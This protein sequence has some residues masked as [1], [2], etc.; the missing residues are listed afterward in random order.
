M[1]RV[2]AGL[3]GF[4]LCDEGSGTVLNDTSGYVSGPT[5]LTFSPGEDYSWNGTHGVDF[6][7]A[8]AISTDVPDA[9]VAAVI[10][11]NEFTVEVWQNVADDAQTSRR[12][13]SFYDDDTDSTY[14]VYLGA[15]GPDFKA[16]YKYDNGDSLLSVS[17]P[18]TDTAGLLAGVTQSTIFRCSLDTGTQDGELFIDGQFTV[19]SDRTPSVGLSS[20]EGTTRVH[21]GGQ[22]ETSELTF[23]GLMLAIYDRALSDAEIL[24]NFNEGPPPFGPTPPPDPDVGVYALTVKVDNDEGTSPQTFTWT[25]QETLLAPVWSTIPDQ[26]D[27][28]NTLPQTLEASLYVTSNDGQGLF[29]WTLIAAPAGF[30]IDTNGR[31][32]CAAGTAVAAHTMSVRV[33][34]VTGTST[35]ATFTWNVLEELLGPQWGTI[36]NQSDDED[37][38]PQVLDTSVYVT[39]N[40]GPLVSW[41]LFSSPIGFSVDQSGVVTCAAGTTPGDHTVTVRVSNDTGTADSIFTW[42]VVAVGPVEYFHEYN[43][44]LGAIAFQRLSEATGY[45]DQ[46]FRVFV[47]VNEPVY[48][49][50]PFSGAVFLPAVDDSWRGLLIERAA[51]NLL[52]DSTDHFSDPPWTHFETTVVDSG[53]PNTLRRVGAG[54]ALV[55]QATVLGSEEYTYSIDVNEH[56]SYPG[57]LYV[58]S[59]DATITQLVP[60]NAEPQVHRNKATLTLANPLPGISIND[61]GAGERLEINNSQLE[62]GDSW[63]SYIKTLSSTASRAFVSHQAPFVDLGLD[64]AAMQNT[65]CGQLK[66]FPTM[67]APFTNA[68]VVFQM[69]DFN[70]SH[71]MWLAWLA[72]GQLYVEFMFS[73]V[74]TAFQSATL[75]TPVREDL[76]DFRWKIG[77]SE[78]KVW[79]NAEVQSAAVV[80]DWLGNVTTLFCGGGGD[81]ANYILRTIRINSTDPGD[82][83]IEG[84]D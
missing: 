2:T 75:T 1:A 39:S 28:E 10:A 17:N 53:D 50:N 76:V 82:A 9:V 52:E 6:V 45:D 35:S 19:N 40:S 67:D 21:F 59:C 60:Y 73:G 80:G 70:P 14:L 84:W 13:F 33:S 81:S 11:S 18:L 23:T 79:F 54:T 64:P 71:Y 4:Y 56:P 74:S 25:I 32:T 20:W 7:R 37:T 30:S 44:A 72:T 83:E 78:V 47:G 58:L 63:S 31:V 26:T 66:F 55:Y 43:A 22:N 36:P 46:P 29:A 57:L 12:T 38:L 24:Q 34:N 61:T 16:R 49:L 15:E 42:T 8:T 41:L 77:A 68:G 48:P 5:H 62:V 65:S 3:V 69:T 27:R 51:T